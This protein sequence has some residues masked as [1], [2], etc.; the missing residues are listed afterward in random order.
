MKKLK[1]SILFI[2]P[3]KHIK[4]FSEIFSQLN[5]NL[6]HCPNPFSYKDLPKDK[7]I[8]AIFTNPNKSNIFI[9]LEILKIYPN[10][11]VITTASTG[12]VHINKEA[13]EKQKIPVISITNERRVISK[14]SSTAEHA[15]CLALAALRNAFPAYQSTLN[16]EWDYEPFIG[17]QFR[18][19]TVGVIGYGR[20]GT[21]FSNYS[22]AFGA[23]VIVY[24]PYKDV[25]HPRIE[26]VNSLD[27]LAI[28]SD[29]V[30][31]HVHVNDETKDMISESFLSKCKKDVK[32]INTSR[33][34][35]VCEKDL[36]NFLS[37]NNYS[38][39]ATDV[40]A[41][42]QLSKKKSPIIKAA[43]ILKNQIIITPHIGGMT[44]EAQLAA[45]T[46][47]AKLLRD[48]LKSNNF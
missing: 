44:V 48:F 12:T 28:K 37:S 15:F 39:Y 18:D 38:F 22:D 23:K 34:E 20:L 5:I 2:T 46:H 10:L 40:I 3:V 41:N 6:V 42:E 4:G 31:L 32:I 47:A 13:F 21:Y 11:K 16:G 17:R 43:K 19:L 14:I 8:I 30:S 1:N 7:S 29:V 35:I 26:Q 24:D 9:D 45:F 27:E 36:I 25:S 33:G